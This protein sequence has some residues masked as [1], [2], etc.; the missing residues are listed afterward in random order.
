[1][2]CACACASPYLSA[3]P[4]NAAKV[5]AASDQLWFEL[6]TAAL[7]HR[8]RLTWFVTLHR[9]AMFLNVFFGTGAVATLLQ[10]HRWVIVTAT[11]MLALV[12]AASLAFDFAGSARKHED[13]RRTYHDL[14][15]QLEECDKGD[16]ACQALRGKMIRAAADDPYVY[17]AAEAVAFNAATQSLGRDVSDE[18]VLTPCQRLLRHVRSYSGAKFPQRKDVGTSPDCFL[19]RLFSGRSLRSAVTRLKA[20][21]A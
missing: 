17:K 20:W 4:A 15:A 2:A 14:A 11:L 12:S 9:A 19:A 10:G 6:T 3:A 21:W 5:S 7:Y 16:A 1:M 18:F 8:D 13:R